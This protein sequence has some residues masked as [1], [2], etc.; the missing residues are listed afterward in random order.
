MKDINWSIGD[1]IAEVLDSYK[2]YLKVK[3]PSHLKTFLQRKKNNIEGAKFE[4]A[5][6]SMAR[7]YNL[8]PKI[9]E[10]IGKGGVDFIC[11]SNDYQLV[12]EVTHLDT[13]SIE[14]QSGLSNIPVNGEARF[15][16]MVTHVLQRKA[17]GKAKQVA[18]YPMPRIL[19]LGA[20]HTAA[21]ILLG[22]HAAKWLLTSETKISIPIG[23]ANPESQ[24]VTD[25]DNSVFFKFNNR[26]EVIPCR[27]SI[28]AILLVVLDNE[29]CLIVGLLHP[30]PSYRFDIAYFSDIPFLKVANWPCSDGRV[31]TEWTIHSP[32]EKRAYL[33]KIELT[34][35]ELKSL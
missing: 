12:L 17:V 15:F 4:A 31:I 33:H 30:E 7:H 10:V 25:L 32:S 20:S 1:S 2:V 16:S 9:G 14:Q 6:F 19:C 5:M 34:A 24:I 3:Y 21:P 35:E 28:S 22:K 29:S 13:D 8:N 27:Q 11:S 23:N 18:D 26:G